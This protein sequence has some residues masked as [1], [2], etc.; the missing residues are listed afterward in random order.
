M[1]A[2]SRKAACGKG[3]EPEDS[4]RQRLDESL[5]AKMLPLF[6]DPV[7]MTQLLLALAFARCKLRHSGRAPCPH[8]AERGTLGRRPMG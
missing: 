4:R 5:A 3:H 6:S 1:A 7:G 2:N 8:S